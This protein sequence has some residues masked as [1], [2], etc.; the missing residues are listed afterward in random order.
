RYPMRNTTVTFPV[1]RDTGHFDFIEGYRVQHSSTLGPTKGGLIISDQYSLEDMQGLAMIMTYKAALVGIP[2]GGSSGLI[3]ANPKDFNLHELERLVRRYTS[4]IINVIGPLQDI[5]G[6]DINTN[7][8]MMT[9][10]ADTYSMGVGHTVHRICTGKPIDVGGIIG[11]DQGVGLGISYILHELARTEFEEIRDHRVVIQGLGHIGRNFL[12]AADEMGAKIIGVSDSQG[13]IFNP[14]GLEVADL[15][16]YKREH[17]HISGFP[18]AQNI[19]NE[20]LLTLECDVLIPCAVPGQITAE[21]ARKL[22]CRRIIEGANAAI[23]HEADKILWDRIIPV[24]PD[25]LANAGGI[26][27]SY[28]EWAQ[29]FTDHAWELDEVHKELKK[30]IVRTF[31]EVY[32]LRTSEDITFR[33]AS[34]RIAV[35]RLADAHEWRGIYP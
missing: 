17:G 35:K 1:R 23:T 21:I 27:V 4:S 13:G 3:V 9:W 18:G 14:Q 22:Q 20:E 28:F 24:I 30:I 5:I 19:S 8:T 16:A 7:S 10:I 25:I 12:T 2:L 26:I 15:I 29:N 34:Y 32:D 11:R 31:H 33:E 6:P